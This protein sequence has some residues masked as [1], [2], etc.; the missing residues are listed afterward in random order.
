MPGAT[1]IPS[2]VVDQVAAVVTPSPTPSAGKIA[3]YTLSDQ[4]VSATIES[5]EAISSM[6]S[7][8]V[9]QGSNQEEAAD[10]SS[11]W[12]ALL[13]ARLADR[14]AGQ[15]VAE[16]FESVANRFLFRLV[17]S[18]HSMRLARSWTF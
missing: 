2:K 8:P 13:P 4:K 15:S 9:T 17:G 6:A 5:A 7:N 3:Q 16:I 11:P 10:E 1:T 18:A 14:F 12:L